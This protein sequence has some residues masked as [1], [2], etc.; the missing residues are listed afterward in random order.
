MKLF[1]KVI[2]ITLQFG[3]VIGLTFLSKEVLESITVPDVFK[4]LSI[5]E[6]EELD[7]GLIQAAVNLKTN[8]YG[9]DE[10]VIDSNIYI[11]NVEAI[12]PVPRGQVAKTI[13]MLKDNGAKTI[14]LS[15]YIDQSYDDIDPTWDT[16]LASAI[17]YKEKNV[18]G[19]MGFQ[20]FIGDDDTNLILPLDKFEGFCD[21]GHGDFER[22]AEEEGAIVRKF[23]PT[24]EYGEEKYKSFAL[25]TAYHFDSTR[26]STVLDRTEPEYINFYKRDIFVQ[27]V[28]GM[29]WLDNPIIA[30]EFTPKIK[31]KLFV[32]GYVT[33]NYESLR[34]SHMESTPVGKL[35]YCLVQTSIINDILTNRLALDSP[36]WVD[37]LLGGFFGLF[38]I[39]FYLYATRKT[40]VW[41]KFTGGNLLLIEI[42]VNYIFVLTIFL[43]LNYKLSVTIPSIVIMISIPFNNIL[44]HRLIPLY[45]QLIARSKYLNTPDYILKLFKNI[46]KAKTRFTRYLT[47]LF[48]FQRILLFHSSFKQKINKSNSIVKISQEIVHENLSDYYKI[49]KEY[50]EFFAVENLRKEL[51]RRIDKGKDI[52]ANRDKFNKVFP[53]FIQLMKFVSKELND[54]ELIYTIKK[55]ENEYTKNEYL[56]IRFPIFSPRPEYLYSEKELALRTVYLNNKTT[57]EFIDMTPLIYYKQCKYHIEKEFFIFSDIY[58]D[59]VT[60]KKISHYIGEHFMCSPTSPPTEDLEHELS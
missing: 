14:A 35:D 39:L 22:T 13:R 49:I 54:Y 8:M 2:L 40:L 18:I 26:A 50:Y 16:S 57:S 45:H 47:F 11:I 23:N 4:N 32:I 51:Y 12:N 38:N 28:W 31:D 30:D 59:N 42:V 53:L 29:S 52:V 6:L 55:T 5:I 60:G 21:I 17:E 56:I 7:Q 3:I 1:K 36:F 20:Y 37:M 15:F 19:I 9:R 43:S 58:Y 34:T 44:H 24:M 25:A 33:D 27:R 41:E 46:F 48:G 10:S